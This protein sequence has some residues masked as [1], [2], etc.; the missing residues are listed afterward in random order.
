M[1]PPPS[2][3]VV[4]VSA[5]PA[6]VALA[7][8]AREWCNLMDVLRASSIPTHPV[9]S[10]PLFRA[11]SLPGLKALPFR[12]QSPIVAE[13]IQ[14]RQNTVCRCW[15]TYCLQEGE[16]HGIGMTVSPPSVR[17]GP[18]LVLYQA[19]DPCGGGGELQAAAK[20]RP[21][22]IFELVLPR[23]Y[24]ICYGREQPCQHR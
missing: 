5:R 1:Q 10:L 11:N 18:T 20:R 4:R 8:K 16:K 17:E 19:L 12:G 24:F 6:S 7:H 23:C 2:D 21:I 13:P 9:S 15:S 3:M 14:A 22:G